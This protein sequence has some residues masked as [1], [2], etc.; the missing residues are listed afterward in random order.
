M[1]DWTLQKW[2]LLAVGQAGKGWVESCLRQSDT[3]AEMVLIVRCKGQG[4]VPNAKPNKEITR[5]HN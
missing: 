4:E 2:S 1:P 3:A 5:I